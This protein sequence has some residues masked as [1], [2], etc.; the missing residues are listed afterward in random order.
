LFVALAVTL[1]CTLYILFSAALKSISKTL[2]DAHYL[3]KDVGTLSANCELIVRSH[4]LALRGRTLVDFWEAAVRR[5]PHRVFVAFEDQ[6]WS[7]HDMDHLV[8]RMARWMRVRT[9]SQSSLRASD[10]R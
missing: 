8:N 3:A 6:Q 5:H 4:Y 9:Q 7:Y 10:A 2:T 1:L